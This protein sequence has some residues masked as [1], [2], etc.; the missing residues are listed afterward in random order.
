M[1]TNV[2]KRDVQSTASEAKGFEIKADSKAF[3]VL[4]DSLYTDKPLAIVRET[5]TNAY[6]AHLSVGKED[7]PFEVILPTV[8]E[9]TFSVRDFGPGMSHEF[10]MGNYSVAFHSEKDQTN[11][12]VGG[13]GL[14][15]MSA[16]SYTDNYSVITRID[17]VKRYYSLII[18]EDSIP[19]VAYLGEEATDEPNGTEV[20]FPISSKD[21]N[22]FAKAMKKVSFGFDVKPIVKNDADFEW[23]AQNVVTEGKFY[24]VYSSEWGETI[25]S[26]AYARM[27]CVVYP[28]DQEVVGESVLGRYSSRAIVIDFPIGSLGVVASREALSYGRKEPT[29]PS[30]RKMFEEIKDDLVSQVNKDLQECKSFGEAFWKRSE[31]TKTLASFEIRNSLNIKWSGEE[32]PDKLVLPK[33][34]S[35]AYT[36]G[37]QGNRKYYDYRST[38]QLWNLTSY[39]NKPSVVYVSDETEKRPIR[40]KE[41]ITKHVSENGYSQKSIWYIISDKTNQKVVEDFMN[42]FPDENYI[43]VND[44]P[45]PGPTAQGSRGPVKVRRLRNWYGEYTEPLEMDPKDFDKGGY[46]I[47]SYQNQPDGSIKVSHP[48]SSGLSWGRVDL[49]WE[50]IKKGKK[51]D[52]PYLIVASR[53]LQKKFKEAKQWIN[54]TEYLSEELSKKESQSVRRLVFYG[55]QNLFSLRFFDEKLAKMYKFSNSVSLDYLDSVYKTVSNLQEEVSKLA[56]TVESINQK[57]YT[58]YPLLK[59]YKEENSEDFKH[60]VKLMDMKEKANV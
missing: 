47:D 2:V 29:V 3:Q 52:Q 18:N 20:T 59:H 11:S 53:P 55:R 23:P 34:L 13:F 38:D 35:L 43:L 44:L 14:G 4:R 48:S 21:T 15:R 46:Y 45:D 28:I 27:G 36:S 1:K 54:L 49:I 12:Q 9:S 32:I 19:E 26:G 41:R 6:D 57:L 30:I 39:H 40:R 60:Y 22:T 50:H 7:V 42:R 37:Y 58:K 5:F 24:K 51:L 25:T 8:W 31:V 56:A 33:A 17:G 10:M 16:F